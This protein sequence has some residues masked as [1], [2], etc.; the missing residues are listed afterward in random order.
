MRRLTVFCS[1]SV[2]LEWSTKLSWLTRDYYLM[3]A[4]NDRI[5]KRNRAKVN[6]LAV[7]LK[8]HWIAL[9]I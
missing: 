7:F 6:M 2:W 5:E 8:H 9:S 4:T 1:V 3:K